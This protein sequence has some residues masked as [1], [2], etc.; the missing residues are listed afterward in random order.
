MTYRDYPIACPRCR[1]DLDRNEASERWVCGTCAGEL[2]GE[3]EV[4]AR[5]VEV[6]PDLRAEGGS[7]L[8][9]LSR[10][11][12]DAPLPCPVCREAMDPVFLGGI[13]VERCRVDELLW[14][15]VSE[16][17]RVVAVAQEQHSQRSSAWLVRAW[18]A[19]IA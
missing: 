8:P 2:W 19:L 5:L 12:K 6:A 14:F 13:E 11:T 10:R 16:I 3:A 9:T 1:R 18:R 17:E 7:R 15:D 4:I